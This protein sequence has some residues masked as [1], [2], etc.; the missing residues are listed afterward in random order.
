M[1]TK[2]NNWYTKPRTGYIFEL[3]KWILHN[4]SAFGVVLFMGLSL[5]TVA[6]I[7]LSVYFFV[8]GWLPA[9]II[10]G[11]FGAAIL[12]KL[13]KLWRLSRDTGIMDVFS[14]M[15]IKDIVMKGKKEVNNN[16]HTKEKDN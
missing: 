11:V 3:S 16:E 15:A 13:V 6:F 7:G 4:P 5:S 12:Y 2:F 14:T 1:K 10:L 9:G 8:K